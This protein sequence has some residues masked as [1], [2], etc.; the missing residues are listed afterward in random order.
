M[1]NELHSHYLEGITGVADNHVHKYTGETSK[2]PDFPGHHH[3]MAGYV[4]HADGHTHYYSFMTGPAIPT[5]H[6]HVH[7]YTGYTTVSHR[8]Y[9]HMWGQTRSNQYREEPKKHFSLGEAR[10]IG[11][12][13]G[14]DWSEFDV[15]QYRT[16][17]DVEF[18]HGR[19]NPQTNITNDDP[20]LTGK[21]TLAHLNEFPDYY[22]RLT[23]MEHDAEEYWEKDKSP[24]DTES[25]K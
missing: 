10:E 24:Y 21:I 19:V 2:D 22:F 9:H 11:D 12:H 25:E 5:P 6:G 14:I 17:L 23:K 16:G 13:L 18:E 3:Y 7:Y 15:D 4:K 8:H 1:A 20:I